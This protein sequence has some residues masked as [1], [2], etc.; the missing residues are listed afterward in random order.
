MSDSDSSEDL[1]FGEGLRPGALSEPR[2]SMTRW[3]SWLATMRQRQVAWQQKTQQYRA[4]GT[5][6]RLS[7]L[8]SY[9]SRT[10][11]ASSSAEA[12]TGARLLKRLLPSGGVAGTATAGGGGST[13]ALGP[14]S[15]DPAPML[16]VGEASSL[17]P[18]SGGSGVEPLSSALGSLFGGG[19]I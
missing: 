12:R 2:G 9:L 16:S 19:V 11:Q 15:V 18:A 4:I 1:G 13:L 17:A 6:R 7:R 14:E 3:Q 10:K 8:W 5:Q